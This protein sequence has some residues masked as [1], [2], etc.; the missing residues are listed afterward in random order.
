MV[1]LGTVTLPLGFPSN[2]REHTF[3]VTP[4]LTWNMILG[5]DFLSHH[6]CCLNAYERTLRFGQEHPA[7]R[8]GPCSLDTEAICAAIAAAFA[9]PP[10]NIESVMPTD[11]DIKE[12]D[13]QAVDCLCFSAGL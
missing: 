4:T 12:Q 9:L 7:V 10:S 13:I 11:P 1:V 3:V 5:L 8:A 6:R 2:T